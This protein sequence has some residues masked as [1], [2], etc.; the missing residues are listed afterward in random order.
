MKYIKLVPLLAF[1]SFSSQ[2]SINLICDSDRCNTLKTVKDYLNNNN[3]SFSDADIFYIYDSN[4][5]VDSMTYS[6]YLTQKDL[7][8]R[9]RRD[10]ALNCDFDADFSCADWKK[11]P[12]TLNLV[13]FVQNYKWKSK[14]LS[15][16][17]IELRNFAAQ[18]GLNLSSGAVFAIPFSGV[19]SIII[20]KV[21]SKLIGTVITGSI[22]SGLGGLA[23]YGINVNTKLKVGDVLIFKNGKIFK[24]VRNGKEYTMR[25]IA[26]LKPTG[27]GSGGGVG[28]GGGYG[29]SGGIV[30]GGGGGFGGVGNTGNVTIKDLL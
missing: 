17:E 19:G 29:G 6:E 26:N 18:L 3:Q 24:V 1:L 14:P 23:L 28:S 11:D 13:N 20:A 2:A 4:V 25:Q 15:N 12:N 5:I 10:A 7:P 9:T 22:T 16:S 27:S 30:G 21:G 8:V